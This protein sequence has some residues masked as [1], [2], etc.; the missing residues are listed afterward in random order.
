[1]KRLKRDGGLVSPKPG[2]T[3]D[4]AKKMD[5]NPASISIPSDWY[6]ENSWSAAMHE[7]K[8]SVQRPVVTFGQTFS[9][10]RSD[11][12]NPAATTTVSARSPELIQKTVG[13]Y[14]SRFTG[15]SA[16]SCSR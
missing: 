13:A 4:G 11:A 5:S 8:S 14:H 16:P 12:I 10:S 2:R 1:M 15:P 3:P 9:T 7:R 6:D